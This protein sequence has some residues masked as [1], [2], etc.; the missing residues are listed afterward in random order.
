[1]KLSQ[2]L[3]VGS[4]NVPKKNAETKMIQPTIMD[5]SFLYNYIYI[6]TYRYI[7]NRTSA[8][9][10]IYTDISM[11]V[12]TRLYIHNIYIYTY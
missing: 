6:H 10:Y 9:V 12:S 1:M 3:N 7:Y 4:I 5:V 11:Y 2:K 8:Y